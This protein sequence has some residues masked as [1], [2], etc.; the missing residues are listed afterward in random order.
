MKRKP[1]YHK[2]V[3]IDTSVKLSSRKDKLGNVSFCV[4]YHNAACPPDFRDYAFFKH[5][6]SAIDFISSNF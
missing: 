1:L 6:S 3:E 5:L 4:E 2:T